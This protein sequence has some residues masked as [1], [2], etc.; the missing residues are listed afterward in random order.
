MGIM[1]AL[2]S[3]ALTTT[4]GTTS[5]PDSRKGELLLESKL[6]GPQKAN[7]AVIISSPDATVDDVAFKSEVEA[8]YG[9][10][11]ALGPDVVASAT[12]YYDSGV[13]GYVSQD[14]H[15][16]IIP[17]VMA[18]DL[19]T[20]ANNID[21]ILKIIDET[22]G[23]SGYK[24][25]VSGTASIGHDFNTAAE[26]D[27]AQ[28]EMIG[29]LIA[30][31]ILILVLGAVV[32]AVVP[33]ILAVV[34]IVAALGVT[35]LVGQ[36]FHL[37]FFVTN[38][39][40]MMGLAVGIDYSL[41]V[42]SRFR[43][44]RL[45]GHDVVTSVDIAS[46]TA[47]HAV[48][49]S[50]L[51]V[52]IALLGML[53][54]PSTIFRSI[55]AGAIFVVSFAII[56]SLTL[57]PAL[58]RLLGDRVNKLRLP[59]IQSLQSEFDEERKGGFWDRVASTVMHHPVIGVVAVTV[60][61]LAFAIPYFDINTGTSGV[62]TLPGSFQSKQGF[63]I[64]ERDFQGGQVTPADIVID[65]AAN[66]QQVKNGIDTLRAILKNDSVFGPSTYT[67]NQAGDLGLLSVQMTVD[68]NS[69]AA[70]DAI[71]RLRNDYIPQAF[72]GVPG[73]V[74]VTGQTAVNVDSLSTTSKYTPII[75][76]FVLG[77]SF[78]LLMLVFRSIVVPAK[79][80]IMNLLSVGSAYGLL[81]LV[82]QKGFLHNILGFQ[83]V[84]TIEFWLPL[85]LFSVLFGL[86]MDYHVFLLSRIRE[87]YDQTKDNTDAV[88]YGLRSTGRLI[89]GAALIMVSVF[90]G[91]AMGSL[92][93]L[94]QVGF[95]LG[96]AVF[97]DATIIRS[98]LVPS[99]MKL[100][101]KANWYLPPVLS[102]LPHLGIESQEPVYGPEGA[103]GGGS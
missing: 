80:I 89:T 43:E 3:G 52:I 97:L 58:L 40:T 32:A 11:N 35:A 88:A 2:L 31:V 46:A 103:G 72:S 61:L 39:I 85:F 36:G 54:M 99:S 65:G 24:V 48:L 5:K 76:A 95:G 6:R 4:A 93:M 90:G 83:Q 74:Y 57:L 102:W 75:F 55:A 69:G 98:I 27:L 68:P 38:M 20:A 12:N 77:L 59:F 91:F 30:L 50:G 81:V 78:I 10:I 70:N 13:E 28:G 94:Q 33:I 53:I 45:R 8:I 22:N 82:S 60:V 73:H 25:Y 34:A 19:D 42:L 96:V 37:S 51:T 16:T 64:L 29:G 7:E 56:A 67:T 21:K 66:S 26:Q 101:G 47:G 71:R 44:E 1:S 15:T 63:Q 92:V 100:L 49:F 79:A 14:R 62:S 9:K 86:S 87:R 18:Q 84:P 23:N 17:V 41:F